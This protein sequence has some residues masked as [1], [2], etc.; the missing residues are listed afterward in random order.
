MIDQACK[1]EVETLMQSAFGERVAPLIHLEMIA[2]VQG[3][4]AGRVRS[5]QK[6]G[7]D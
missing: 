7:G 4:A 1:P 6:E 3:K 2:C 5:I